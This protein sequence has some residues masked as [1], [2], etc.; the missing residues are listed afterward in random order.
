M[1]SI[2]TKF[3]SLK[4]QL[5]THAPELLKLKRLGTPNVGENIKELE[6]LYLVLLEM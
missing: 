1:L 5:T 4:P 3:A 6:Y 2:I